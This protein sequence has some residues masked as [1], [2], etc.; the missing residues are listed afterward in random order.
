MKYVLLGEVA[1]AVTAETE[2]CCHVVSLQHVVRE[3]LSL[4]DGQVGL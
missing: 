1:N 4:Y 2:W 3:E